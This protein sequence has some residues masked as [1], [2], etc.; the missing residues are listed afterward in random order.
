M[1]ILHT[2]DL[3]L[4]ELGNSRW[5]ALEKIVDLCHKHGVSVLTISGDLFDTSA[6]A[7]GLRPHIRQLFDQASFDTL[8]IPGNHDAKAFA[9]GFYF[10][11]RVRLMINSDWSQNS[12][13]LEGARF[14]GIPFEELDPL[15]F[16][17]KLRELRV[18]L[19]PDASNLLLYHGEL[20]DASFD[21]KDF[22]PQ[23][24]ARY[25]PTRLAFFEELPVNYV[26]AGHFH[27]NFDVRSIGAGRYFIYPGSPVSITRREVGRR[28][29]ALFECGQEPQGVPVDTHHFE[30][31]E[32]MLN[33]FT[34][35][36]PREVLKQRLRTVDR[37]ATIL[38]TVSGTIK[39]SE[40][41]LVGF[42]KALTKSMRVETEFVFKD[43]SEVISHPVFELFERK[44]AEMCNLNEGGID[45][46][47]AGRL[48]EL[49][50]R[51]MVEAEL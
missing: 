8:I 39:G 13:E 37:D 7:D 19:D 46:V 12:F 41:D 26:L 32:I 22:G 49:V 5:Q 27:R 25:M 35:E 51:A 10:G 4:V 17:A 11:E 42:V 18:L 38:L 33:A 43:I 2:A 44:L 45:Q 23:E 1:K 29:I 21:R 14:L 16:R 47:E 20:L 50:V 6:D 34:D 15:S 24:E 3:H 48:R 36:Q 31:V 40:A 30:A 28:L 9:Q